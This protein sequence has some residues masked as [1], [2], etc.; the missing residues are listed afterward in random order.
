[1]T[2]PEGGT[3]PVVLTI[4]QRDGV[5]AGLVTGFE[6]GAEIRL[7]RVSVEGTQ[8]VAEAT[9][10]S[11]LGTIT[12]RYELSPAERALTGVQRYVLGAHTIEFPVE[13]KRAARAA[14]GRAAPRLLPR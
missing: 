11:E 9:A 8:L 10:E 3:A 13:L 14:T 4:V 6:D 12:V 7:A 2:L 5:Y 1:M